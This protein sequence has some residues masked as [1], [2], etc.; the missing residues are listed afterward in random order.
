[1]NLFSLQ[2]YNTAASREHQHSGCMYTQNH[3]TTYQTRH[4]YTSTLL[5]HVRQHLGITSH[6]RH[7]N[8]NL[9]LNRMSQLMNLLRPCP[10]IPVAF[11]RIS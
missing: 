8:T 1:M 3:G 6:T 9:S 5:L 4:T 11:F 2:S 10:W 7:T